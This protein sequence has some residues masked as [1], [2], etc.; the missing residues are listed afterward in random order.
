MTR[1]AKLYTRTVTKV[2][3]MVIKEPR[4]TVRENYLRND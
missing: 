2:E 3:Q 4:K 1:N